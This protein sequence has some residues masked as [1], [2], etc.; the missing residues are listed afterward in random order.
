MLLLL[1]FFTAC[2]GFNFRLADLRLVQIEESQELV[3]KSGNKWRL[4]QQRV[5][6]ILSVFFRTS[7]PVSL[8]FYQQSARHS[9]HCSDR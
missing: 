6:R 3:Q 1:L 8:P 5:A 4:A 2:C 7:R 9:S